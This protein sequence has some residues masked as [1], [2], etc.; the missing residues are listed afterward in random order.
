M[1]LS[2]YPAMFSHR[3]GAIVGHCELTANAVVDSKLS[4][5]GLPARKKSE[6]HIHS[7]YNTFRAL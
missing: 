1:D 5:W 3:L 2:Q 7:F 4:S 6:R